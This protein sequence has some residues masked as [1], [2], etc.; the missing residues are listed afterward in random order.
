MLNVQKT[1]SNLSM[2]PQHVSNVL[3]ICILMEQD[4]WVERNVNRYNVRIVC[5][6]MADFAYPWD[7]VYNVYAQLVS[8]EDA[9]KLILTSVL[10]NLVTMAPRALIFL[11]VTDVNVQTDTL[12]LTAKKKNLTAAM[13]LVLREL[14]AKMSLVLTITLVYVDLV[15]LALIVT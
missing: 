12:V 5:V 1:S 4:Q 13:T 14:C 9:V 8:L 2:E 10:L 11:K 7:M 6:N 3:P 15:I